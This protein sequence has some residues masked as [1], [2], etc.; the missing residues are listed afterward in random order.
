MDPE[1]FEQTLAQEKLFL[2]M[3][4]YPL[5]S[6]S[7]SLSLLAGFFCGRLT[8]IQYATNEIEVCVP[9]E[10]TGEDECYFE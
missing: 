10:T 6:I 1:I 9:N 8:L 3:R 5:V 4:A 7:T 2:K